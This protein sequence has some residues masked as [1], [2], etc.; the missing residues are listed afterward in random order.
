[1][2]ADGLTKVLT[3]PKHPRFLDQLG[4]ISLEGVVKGLETQG[5][6]KVDGEG[7][8]AQADFNVWLA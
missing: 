8:G 3:R 7:A 5:D 6:S 2:A 4:M 1:M